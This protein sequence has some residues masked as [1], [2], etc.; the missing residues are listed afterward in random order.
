MVRDAEAHAEEDKRKRERIEARNQLDSLIYSTEKS[1]KDHRSDIDDATARNIE[2]ALETAKKAMES[3]DAS[4]IKSATD[5]L[6]QASHK[7]AEA[8]YARVAK[9]Q[10]GAQ[11]SQPEEPRGDG[12]AQGQGKENVVDADFEEVK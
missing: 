4:V 6:T 5:E 11:G 12:Q 1:L 3:E 8:M 9:E 10:A 7:L 2:A